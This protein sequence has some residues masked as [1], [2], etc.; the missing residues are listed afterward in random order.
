MNK[1]RVLSRSLALVGAIL[2]AAWS[3]TSNLDT[4]NLDT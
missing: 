3:Y 4:S 1:P 2:I